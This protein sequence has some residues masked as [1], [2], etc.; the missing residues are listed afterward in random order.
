[1]IKHREKTKLTKNLYFTLFLYVFTPCLLTV[2]IFLSFFYVTTMRFE[3]NEY[4]CQNR[5]MKS[6][7][8]NADLI[9]NNVNNVGKTF[10]LYDEIE[11]LFASDIMEYSADVSKVINGM[12]ISNG[13]IHSI[14][15]YDVNDKRVLDD[16]GIY[17]AREY[18]ENMSVY[19]NYAY[20]YWDNFGYYTSSSYKILSPGTLQVDAG[21]VNV[22]PVVFRKAGNLSSNRYLI[23]NI[24]LKAVF[25]DKDMHLDD[26]TQY[27][28]LNK[29]T[30]YIFPLND[31]S[32]SRIT[33]D[34][35][36][37]KTIKENPNSKFKYKSDN[38]YLV[39]T[40]SS[41][42]SM[43]GYTFVGI[44]DS[45][46]IYEDFVLFTILMMILSLFVFVGSFF[47]AFRNVKMIY[48]PIKNTYAMLSGNTTKNDRSILDEMEVLSN[49]SKEKIEKYSK[50][51]PYAQRNY[52]INMLNGLDDY[53]SGQ[54]EVKKEVENSLNFRYE[55]YSVILFQMSPLA[56]FYDMFSIE[57]YETIRIGFYNLVTQMFE[58]HFDTFVLPSEDDVLTI[59]LNTEDEECDKISD[60]IL[61]NILSYLKND[62][63][64]IKISLGVG[65]AYKGI[66][67]L[68][69]SYN[70]AMSN[71]II[72]NVPSRE[73]V[74]K[75][76]NNK[77]DYLAYVE[78]MD[79]LTV[80]ASFD[81]SKIIKTVNTFFAENSDL[82]IHDI[83]ILYNYIVN[84]TLNFMH[85]H[86]I[87]Y[88][89]N[90]MYDYEIVEKMLSQTVVG[91][92]NEFEYLIE[93]ICNCGK[94][95]VHFEDINIYLKNN[96]AIK[97]LSLIHIAD[98]FNMSQSNV[99][100]I[101][102]NAV[103]MTFKKYLTKIRIDEA[104]AMLQ[105]GN[106][107]VDKI[108]DLTGFTSKRTFF[109][110]FKSETG[111]TPGDYKNKN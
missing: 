32:V 33:D 5:V 41:D 85:K 110:V 28:I 16:T 59:V 24:D 94:G 101:I 29:Y 7:M 55:N 15:I 6:V 21:M 17:G 40:K 61:K 54:E 102:Q 78:K 34:R 9:L 107:S 100:R 62:M 87:E 105:N 77:V 19:S 72:Y 57:E 103:G 66:E 104:K 36:L 11:E 53:T 63:E 86:D 13:S 10:L 50:V 27:Y 73:P 111:T 49:A 70:D 64:Y 14:Y 83:K 88:M 106:Y 65:L 67:G 1:M 91:I 52:I 74:L 44:L 26:K 43:I 31:Y 60:D 93:H 25:S 92:R 12:E 48:H 35:G 4:D 75:M 84:I 97:D 89:D 69:Q 46:K 22:I 99:T 37:Q 108:C 3:E 90:R 2:I 109:R 18:F 80:L 79:L 38:K 96:Y 98:K 8:S 45:R 58:E 76:K 95:D 51:L 82:S 71:F 39:V 47:L 42:N 68:K 23:F 30:D 20:E 81:K 56:E